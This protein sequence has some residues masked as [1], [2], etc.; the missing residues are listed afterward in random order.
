MNLTEIQTS[1]NRLTPEVQKNDHTIPI[2]LSILIFIA[3]AG[4]V[5]ILHKQ[6]R[7]KEE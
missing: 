5:Y 4:G 2:V 7:E 3:V 6:S 1:F